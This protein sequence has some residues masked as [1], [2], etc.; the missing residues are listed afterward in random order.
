MRRPPYGRVMGALLIPVLIVVAL[1]VVAV[2]GL[3]RLTKQR[4][5]EAEHVDRPEVRTVR[6]RI[7]PGAD[8]AVAIS[9]LHQ[10]GY[11]AVEDHAAHEIVV[12]IDS[13]EDRVR[14]ARIIDEAPRGF[15]NPET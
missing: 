6:H 7:E 15:E 5:A 12:P 8:P 11:D 13:A 1:A 3:T 4:T 10:A 14:V 2:V 9:A